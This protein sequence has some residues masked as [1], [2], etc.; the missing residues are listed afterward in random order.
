MQANPFDLQGKTFLVTGASSGLGRQICIRISEMN[1]TVILTARNLKRLEET[2]QAMQPGD[3]T[4]IPADLTSAEETENLVQKLPKL[5]GVAFSTGISI[6]APTG[7]ITQ[8][9]YTQT[10]Q[11]NFE[12]SL[13]LSNQLI[14][15]KKLIRNA[16]S[17]VFISS[18][19]TRYP[20]V[21]GALYVSAKAAMEGYARVLA[22]ELAHKGI[23]VNCVSPAFVKTQMLNQ[24][25]NDFSADVVKKIEEK[26]LLGLGEPDDVAN[27][28]VFF[29]SDASKWIT[30]TNLILGG[31]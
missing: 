14:R 28:V 6:I 25:T 19:S 18:I 29:L 5:N 26:Q 11:T 4:L 17:L 22:I 1:G 23:R 24:T 20:F 21:G 9:D 8:H 27:P 7:F 31:G 13:M 15:K 2:R 30:A 10:F 3:H 16:C 12:A